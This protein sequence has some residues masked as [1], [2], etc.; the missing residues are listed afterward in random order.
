MRAPVLILAL[1]VCNC[2]AAEVY[3]TEGTN[4]RID[5]AA[6]GR[7]AIDLHNSGELHGVT[8]EEQLPLLKRLAKQKKL[9]ALATSLDQ[10]Y[11]EN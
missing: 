6:D 7:V 4:I 11:P 8:I 5:V 2:A 3:L 9:L 1:A 10:R